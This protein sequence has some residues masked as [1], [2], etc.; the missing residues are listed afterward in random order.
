[1]TL[2]WAQSSPLV[3]LPCVFLKILVL[4]LTVRSW[5]RGLC[6]TCFVLSNLTCSESLRLLRPSESERA[7]FM[8]CRA[9][10]LSRVPG[11]GGVFFG[12]KCG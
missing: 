11:T 10:G 2:E 12:R 6:G 8:V 1:M 7:W 5:A 4:A 9:P 3:T